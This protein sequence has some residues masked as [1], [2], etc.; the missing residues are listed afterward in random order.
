MKPPA[1][2]KSFNHLIYPIEVKSG[3]R[4]TTK[5]LDKFIEVFHN[6]I[7]EAYIIHTKNLTQ[8]NGTFC[9][10]AYMTFCL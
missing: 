1:N 7:G 8:Q 4:Y 2:G 6:R 10:P 9:I 3:K 5:S